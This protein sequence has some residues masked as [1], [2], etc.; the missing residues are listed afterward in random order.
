MPAR[1]R[2]RTRRCSAPVAGVFAAVLLL[3]GGQAASAD[4][5]F[6]GLEVQGIEARATDALGSDISG[7][8]VKDVAVGEA[9][10]IA[11]FRR[12]D[13]IVEFDG[14]KIASFDDLLKQVAKTKPDQKISVVVLR[15]GKK[16]ELTLRTTPKPASWTVPVG[17]F[18]N[19]PELGLTVAGIDDDARKRFD[20][21]WGLT[22]LVVTIVDEKNKIVASGLHP[23]E[24]IA[25]ANLRDLWEPR[26]LTR[27]IEDAKKTN[28]PLLLLIYGKGGFRYSVLPLN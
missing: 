7:V 5:G 15:L 26:H 1:D 4:P 18:Q 12:G 6:L 9:G 13:L 19:Y 28:R 21:P 10:A 22:G 16:T 17:Q 14:A 27:A 20:V 8:L 25:Q 11:G 3:L 24:V 23:G 2:L